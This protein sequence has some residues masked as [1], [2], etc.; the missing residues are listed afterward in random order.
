MKV[1]INAL[2]DLIQNELEGEEVTLVRQDALKRLRIF[3]GSLGQYADKNVEVSRPKMSE[4]Y[5][6]ANSPS[7]TRASQPRSRMK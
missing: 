1:K 5:R 2:L 6:V 3:R 7:P 4:E